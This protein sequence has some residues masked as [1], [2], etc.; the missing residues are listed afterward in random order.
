MARSD[1]LVRLVAGTPAGDG[2]AVADEM[3]AQT[4]ILAARALPQGGGHL[5]HVEYQAG[6]LRPSGVAALLRALGRQGRIAAL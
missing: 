2:Q 4:G 1:V 6:V 5:L 3:A